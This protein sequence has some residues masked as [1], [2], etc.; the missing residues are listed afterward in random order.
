MS[1]RQ[2]GVSASRRRRQ[3]PLLGA[4]CALGRGWRHSLLS[5][6][7]SRIESELL[8]CSA[9]LGSQIRVREQS[10]QRVAEPD[11]VFWFRQEPGSLC[12]EPSWD[13]PDGEAHDGPGLGHSFKPYQPEGFLPTNAPDPPLGTRQK[14]KAP[15]DAPTMY[16]IRP[17]KT[18]DLG[19]A[20]PLSLRNTGICTD[21]V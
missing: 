13:A 7:E 11:Y 12:L 10:S 18:I 2:A 19:L 4:I 5:Q 16:R 21:S 17:P 20:T 1:N 15:R 3:K 9:E 8:A 6:L 14:V